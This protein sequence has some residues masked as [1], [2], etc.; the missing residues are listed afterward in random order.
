MVFNKNMNQI[1]FTANYINSIKIKK[2]EGEKYKPFEVSLAELNLNNKK[3][4]FSLKETSSNWGECFAEDIYINSCKP[5][6]SEYKNHVYAL[7]TQ[8]DNSEPLKP[9]NTLGLVE[10]HEKKDNTNKIEFLQVQPDYVACQFGRPLFKKIGSAII[11]SLKNLY[12]DKPI[13]LHSVADAK[14]FYQK[15]QFVKDKSS[16]DNLDLIWNG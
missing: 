10:F 2:L 12:P 1:N 5:K 14:T 15:H 11:K 13:K 6:N 3:D 9:N 4:I 16:F 8:K 7:T